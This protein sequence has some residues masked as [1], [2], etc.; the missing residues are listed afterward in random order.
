MPEDR[1]I[2]GEP[3]KVET[4]GEG[5]IE[6]P[7][8]ADPAAPSPLGREIG[9]EIPLGFMPCDHENRKQRRKASA[10]WVPPKTMQKDAGAGG[11][12]PAPDMPTRREL[13][14]QRQKHQRGKLDPELRRLT[15][16]RL[17]Q[18]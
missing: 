5:V 1:S 15:K 14:E 17:K 8:A 2:L 18:K 9:T 12:P 4:I 3:A 6:G 16:E 10:T 13:F 7:P 11:A